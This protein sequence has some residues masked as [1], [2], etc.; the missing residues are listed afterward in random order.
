MVYSQIPLVVT[1][2]VI[3][4]SIAIIVYSD[5]VLEPNNPGVIKIAFKRPICCHV[6]LFLNKRRITEKRQRHVPSLVVSIKK[7]IY[8]NFI[9]TLEEFKCLYL[10]TTGFTGVSVKSTSTFKN[11]VLLS[12]SGSDMTLHK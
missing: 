8:L 3:L 7:N 2:C 6:R 1:F 4:M 12:E 10:Q 9:H 5:A 11:R